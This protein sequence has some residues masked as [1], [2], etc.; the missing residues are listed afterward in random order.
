MP[1]AFISCGLLQDETAFDHVVSHYI[2]T[3]DTLKQYAAEYLRSYAHF[4]YGIPR[5]LPKTVNARNFI[6]THD[7][8][9]RYYWDSCG[10]TVNVGDAIYD[11]DTIT[12]KYLIDNI[13]LAFDSWN[14]PWA[15]SVSFDEFCKYILPYRN[16]D[17]ELSNWRRYF[18]TRYEYS[19]IDSV[20]DPTSIEDVAQYLIRCLRREITYGPRTG[21]ICQDLMRPEDIE[22]LHWAGCMNAA[23]YTTLAMRACGVPCAHIDIHWRFTEVTHSSVLF[24]EVGNNKRAFRLTIGDTLM[25]MG[26]PK[27]TMAAYRVWA[28]SYEPNLSLL[29]VL[30]ESEQKEEE[31]ALRAFALPVTRE[32]VTAL[33]CKTYNFSLPIPDSLRDKGP[34][35]LCRFYQ[36]DW[37]PVRE[38]MVFND[39]VYFRDATIRQLYRL[40]CF[41]NDSV[42]TYGTPFTLSGN[43]DIRVC[44]DRIR[45]YNHTGDTVLFKRVYVCSDVETQTEKKITTFYW[46]ENNRWKPYTGLSHLWGFNKETGEY[47]L[48]DESISKDFKPVFYLLE[49][50]LPCWTVF[51]DDATP[52]PLGFIAKDSLSS[53]GYFMEVLN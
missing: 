35:F 14:R 1:G 34:L 26:A 40:G 37:H 28:K 3:G 9:F 7:S 38:G 36:W 41:V 10:F 19:I 20:S 2:M 15:K 21:S 31:T 29:K 18:K 17:E 22:R 43:P 46:N 49:I 44:N 51:T 8:I 16:G 23:H 4:H 52:R 6:S 12:E 33:F 32:D 47:R 42:R 24:P 25:Y 45:P 50:K 5:H 11:I 53:E 13:D 27:D 39:S 48:Y 30:R